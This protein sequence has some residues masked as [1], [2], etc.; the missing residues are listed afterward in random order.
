MHYFPNNFPVTLEKTKLVPSTL[1]D[2][3]TN[4]AAHLSLQTCQL[5]ATFLPTWLFHYATTKLKQ[6]LFSIMEILSTSP[7][8]LTSVLQHYLWHLL[9]ANTRS[10]EV[11]LFVSSS[12]S[13]HS[14]Q[15]L[16]QPQELEGIIRLLLDRPTEERGMVRLLSNQRYEPGFYS[17]CSQCQVRGPY[18]VKH[19]CRAIEQALL[20]HEHLLMHQSDSRVS[21]QQYA[22]ATLIGL[23]SS[24][25]F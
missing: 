2:Q 17:Q 3:N 15:D 6:L 24:S 20:M 23:S 14:L 11:P 25:S 22:K 12:P 19:T 13:P 1:S 16:V 7:V 9:S 5:P 10:I 8:C 21:K 18:A 4:L